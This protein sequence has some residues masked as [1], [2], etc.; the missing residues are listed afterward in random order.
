[1]A[2]LK[3]PGLA[4]VLSA[5]IPGLGQIYNGDF[6]RTGLPARAPDPVGVSGAPDPS[7]DRTGP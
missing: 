3:N 7:D 1:M 5:L 6:L 2:D 4:A